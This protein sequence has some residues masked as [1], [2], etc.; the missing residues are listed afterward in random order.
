MSTET[1]NIII[2]LESDNSQKAPED[3]NN[4]TEITDIQPEFISIKTEVEEIPSIPEVRIKQEPQYYSEEPTS[5]PPAPTWH[6]PIK[7]EPAA[8]ESRNEFIVS[9]KTEPVD[10]DCNYIVEPETVLVEHPIFEPNTSNFVYPVTLTSLPERYLKDN[11]EVKYM[12]LICNKNFASNANLQRHLPLHTRTKY[13]C[14]VCQ[15]EF[16]KKLLLD[17]HVSVHSGEK[18][19]D[20]NDCGKKFRTSSNLFQHKRIHAIHKEFV[21]EVCHRGFAVKS[22]LLKHQGKSRCKRPIDQPIVCHVCNKVFK[23]EFLLK[24]HLRRHTTDKPFSCELC[25]MNFKYKSTLI[26]HIQL[27][28]GLKP[29][30]CSICNK[31]FTHPGLIKPHMRIHTGEK[32]YE[33]PVCNKLFAHKHNM[34]RHALRHNKV[35]HLTCDV[36]MKKF[37]KES[38]LKYHMKTHTNEKHFSCNVCPKKFSHKQNVLR[39]YTRKHPNATYECKETDASVALKVWDEV[40]KK[41]KMLAENS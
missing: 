32:P 29:Y 40:L 9:V 23:R 12:C 6:R 10:P 37:P 33:C 17:K 11:S 35:K 36:C 2:Q 34:Q 8:Q 26:R 19:Y 30:A 39:H 28:N 31:S 7:T 15:K 41:K 38:R 14:H 4:G 3:D 27:H 22:N 5:P 20:C 25:D 1:T 18:L 21:C 16:T 13:T 24:S